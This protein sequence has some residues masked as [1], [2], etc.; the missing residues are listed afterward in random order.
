MQLTGS[1]NEGVRYASH[2]FDMLQLAWISSF[3]V[4]LPELFARIYINVA[5]FLCIN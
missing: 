4:I 1:Q 5:Q 3:N 2:L